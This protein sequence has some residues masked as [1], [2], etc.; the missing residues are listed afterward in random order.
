MERR[1][2]P[3]P[4]RADRHAKAARTC[5]HPHCSTTSPTLER[6]VDLAPDVVLPGH[7]KPFTAIDVLERRLRTHHADRA[8]AVE[9]ILRD[10]GTATA[11][12]I[13]TRLLWQPD[14]YRAV[15]GMAEVAT[16]LDLLEAARRVEHH[17]VNG[18]FKYRVS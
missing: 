4:H 11:W 18:R 16:H 2:P 15:L 5:G 1:P 3:R 13:A 17:E 8:D 12:D 9:A 10:F 7:G 14:G 6:Y